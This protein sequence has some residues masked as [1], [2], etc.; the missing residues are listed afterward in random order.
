MK[1]KGTTGERDREGRISA[2]LRHGLSR[3]V[4]PSLEED[5]P[6]HCLLHGLAR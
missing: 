2:L 3:T 5:R 1:S 4:S 6:F